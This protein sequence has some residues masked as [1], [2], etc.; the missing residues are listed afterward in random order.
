MARKDYLIQSFLKHDLLRDK[1]G[2]TEEEMNYPLSY[3]LEADKPIICTIARL[4][5][6]IEDNS[7]MSDARLY[8]KIIQ[9]LNTAAI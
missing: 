2:I 9:Y 6:E 7:S 5:D 1:Y 8:E 3:A 4:I